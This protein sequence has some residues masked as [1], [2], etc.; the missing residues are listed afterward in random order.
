[1]ARGEA[2]IACPHCGFQ[3][4]IPLMALQRDTYHGSRCGSPV[5]LAAANEPQDSGNRPPSRP[6]RN[7]QRRRRR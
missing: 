1:M 6:R 4:R 5:S 7:F 2:Y 3:S